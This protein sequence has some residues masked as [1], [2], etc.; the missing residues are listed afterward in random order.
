MTMM[1]LAWR[2]AFHLLEL[3]V[4]G[5]S[6]WYWYRLTYRWTDRWAA[7]HS[8]PVRRRNLRSL[9]AA[10]FFV[11]LAGVAYS[12]WLA[13]DN[14]SHYHDSP[15]RWWLNAVM[16]VYVVGSLV[17]GF[18]LGCIDL[19]AQF[20]HRKKGQKVAVSIQQTVPAGGHAQPETASGDAP[21]L[22]AVA[23]P[24]HTSTRRRFLVTATGLVAVAPFAVATYGLFNERLD[25]E[26]THVKLPMGPVG[27]ALRGRTI[28]QISDIHISPFLTAR[29]LRRVVDMVN[30]L[31][32]D[33]IVITGDFVTFKG[34]S[35]YDCVRELQRLRARTGM[36]GCLGNHEIYTKTEDSITRLCRE[37]DIDI[38]RFEGR[39]IA[40][41]NGYLNI[42]GVDYLRNGEEQRVQEVRPF[43]KEG[44]ANLLL[45]HNPNAFDALGDLPVQAML[46][47]H[48]HGGQMRV[49]FLD[50]DI[51]PALLV[52]PYIAGMYRRPGQVLYVNRG[53]GTVGLPIRIGAAPEIT[54]YELA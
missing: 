14:A 17:S 20:A 8:S 53:L 32:A 42:A 36:L 15:F 31:N 12:I 44:E 18:I 2:I 23:P 13:Q 30:E 26:I 35:Q 24:R 38:L 39:R 47:G 11:L 27:A 5:F 33:L 9:H 49:E 50:V 22:P 7:R 16:A 41:G 40:L 51:T 45:S 52:S 21:A 29:D 3:A 6:Q 46:A 25:F 19:A 10:A 34:E 28:A 48:T 1:P 37:R 54:L 43:M 4:F